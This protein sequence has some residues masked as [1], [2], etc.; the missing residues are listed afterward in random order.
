ML[1]VAYGCLSTMPVSHQ[2]HC[3]VAGGE[4]APQLLLPFFQALQQL[5][6][7]LLVLPEALQVVKLV[8][9]IDAGGMLASER[10]L[11]INSFHPVF[12]NFSAA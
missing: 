8:N 2:P 1:T 5:L 7:L 9:H 10:D 3:A 12:A 4:G 6:L 11:W